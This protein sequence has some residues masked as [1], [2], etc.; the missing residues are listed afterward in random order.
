MD[1]SNIVGILAGLFVGVLILLVIWTVVVRRRVEKIEESEQPPKSLAAVS[2]ARLDAGELPASPI[3]EQ[4]EEM[5]KQQL[6]QYPD[7]SQ[8]KLDFATAS[9]ESLEIWVDDQRYT[10]VDEI[11]DE[12]IRSAISEAVQTFNK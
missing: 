10:Q 8:V 12:R 11:P 1:L 6:A 4:I 9:D 7:L 2:D 5:V 3:S